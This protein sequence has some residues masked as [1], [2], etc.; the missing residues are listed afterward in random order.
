VWISAASVVIG[1]KI[2]AVKNDVAVNA[3]FACFIPVAREVKIRMVVV[4][5]DH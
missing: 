3:L 4:I 1:G 5:R 2:G